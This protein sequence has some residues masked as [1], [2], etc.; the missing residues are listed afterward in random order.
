MAPDM[1]EPRPGLV[2]IVREFF[3]ADQLMR[4]LFARYRAGELR[5][6]ELGALVSDDEGSVL[7]RLKEHCHALFRSGGPPA[8]PVSHREALFDLAVGSLF[9]EAMKFRE[10]FYQRE[11]YGPRVR[12]LRDEADAEARG[13]FREFERMLAVGTERLEEGLQECE[14]LLG[15]TGDQLRVLLV[16]HRDNGYLAR[17]L[18]EQP[19]IVEAVFG[20]PLDRVLA[21]IHGDA[22]EGYALAARSYLESGY[23]STADRTFAEA[24]ERG[25][26]RKRLEPLRACAQGMNAYLVGDYRTTLERL[27]AWS[28]AGR[29]G[30]PELGSLALAAVSRLGQLVMGPDRE[31]IGAAAESLARQLSAEPR[32]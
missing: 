4:Q 21:E 30:G 26:A 13:L 22:A 19:A 11:I 2:Q 3:E 16:L 18:V 25:G 15:Q 23:Y 7:F 28:H 20:E 8:R 10:S 24:I 5:F 1:S 31:P 6:P 29:P 9:H 27:R 12:A 17:F 14:A 32:K